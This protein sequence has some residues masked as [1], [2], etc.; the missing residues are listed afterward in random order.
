MLI[1]AD[2]LSIYNK[3]IRR[4]VYRISSSKNIVLDYNDLKKGDRF[5]YK[6]IEDAYGSKGHGILMVANIPKFVETRS[7][8][9]PQSYRL[10]HLPPN[11]LKKY[12]RPEIFHS[13][14][15]SCGVEQFHGKYDTSKGSFYSRV[16]CDV[17]PELTED[18]KKHFSK[19]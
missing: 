4:I 7:K 16:A 18:Q 15:W 19:L 8:L 5:F 11:I 14:G 2:R 10:A 1:L 17:A 6:E 9:L 12:E 13:L 3:M